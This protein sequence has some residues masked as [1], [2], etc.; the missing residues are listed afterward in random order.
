[1]VVVNVIDLNAKTYR[2]NGK[3]LP[4]TVPVNNKTENKP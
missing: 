2:K 4:Q 3:M 1:M